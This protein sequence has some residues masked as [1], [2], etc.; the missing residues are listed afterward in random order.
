MRC[1]W[2]G[3][4]GWGAVGVEP[5]AQ[6]MARFYVDG[7]HV[8]LITA[9]EEVLYVPGSVSQVA[10]RYTPVQPVLNRESRRSWRDSS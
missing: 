2:S 5:D 10:G 4:G 7:A 3:W 1:A 8:A 9:Y 6:V